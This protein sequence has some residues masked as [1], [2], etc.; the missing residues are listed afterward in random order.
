MDGGL[1]GCGSM[2]FAHGQLVFVSLVHIQTD[3][4]MAQTIP[5]NWGTCQLAKLNREIETHSLE[6]SPPFTSISFARAEDTEGG[7]LKVCSAVLERQ[8]C[9]PHICQD[10]KAPT[11]KTNEWHISMMLVARANDRL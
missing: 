7:M 9:T 10:K 2:N 8:A 5:T 4:K 1:A 11:V 3:A 6:L